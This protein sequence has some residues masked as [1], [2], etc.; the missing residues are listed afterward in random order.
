[1]K[2]P[3]LSLAAAALLAF[4]LAL[5]FPFAAAQAPASVIAGIPTPESVLGFKPGADFHLANYT[6]AI[7]YFRKL[8]AASHRIKL[9]DVGQ[10]SRGQTLVLS[11]ISSPE[12]LANLDKYLEI[13]RRLTLASGLS[14]AQ[15]HALAGQGKVVVHIDGG[16]HSTEVAGGQSMIALAYNLCAAQND[17]EINAILNNVIFVLWPTLNPD[18][19]QEVVAWYRRNVGT[20]FEV[21]PIPFLFQ[22]YVG[23]DNNRDGYMNNM[24]ESQAIT[25]QELKWNPEIWYT[26]HQTAPFPARIFIPPFVDPISP[27][28]NPILMRWLNQIGIA[29]GAYLD[30]HNMPGAIHRV[31]FDNWYPGYQDFT[32]IFR[33]SIAFFTETA[34]YGYATPHFYTLRDFPPAYRNLQP[35][36]F[37]NSPWRGGWWRLGDAVHYMV[38]AS[39]SVLDTAA[40]YHAQL[41][42]NK[43]QA[44]RD[45]IE[46]Y[47]K[48]PPYAYVIPAGQPRLAEAARLARVFAV[49]GV[50]VDQA[51]QPFLANHRSY[52]AGS[53][54]ILMDQPFAQLVRELI[55][56]QAYPERTANG[57]PIRPYDVA[58]WTLPEQMNVEVDAVRSPVTAAQRAGLQPLAS[59]TTP[60]GK[61]SGSGGV[62]LLPPDTNQHFYAMNLALDQ[63][64][65]VSIVTDPGPGVPAG[66][67]AISNLSR[68]QMQTIL[69][70]AATSAR[71]VA[72]APA[73]AAD[74]VHKPR[75]G[76]YRPWQASIDMGWTR[77]ILQNYDF[78]PLL[79]RNGDIQAS[80]LN[81]RLDVI[82]LAD[83]YPG[84]ILNGFGPGTM[85][86][87]YVG[88]IGKTGVDAL[89]TFVQNGGTLIC[90]NQASAFAIQQ[91]GLPVTNVLS[92]VSSSKFYSSGSL[93]WTHVE[94]PELAGTW[95]MPPAQ[96]V[97]FDNS[98]AFATGEG[99]RGHILAV[100]P[101]REDPLASGFLQGPEFLEG[102]AAEVE[103][104]YGKGRIYLFGFKPNWRAQAHGAYPLIFNAI[105]DSPASSHPTE[106][107]FAPTP[108]AIPPKEPGPGAL[109]PLTAR[110]GGRF[111]GGR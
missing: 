76:L 70:S 85:P 35:Q 38:G 80:D 57:S 3:K 4:G 75:V 110:R 64:A 61:I 69:N 72:S 12:N 67:A 103:A 100:Y 92:G 111:G 105:Y 44:G 17:P 16:M 86:G 21:S 15:A 45:T 60:P 95:G 11:V 46:Q 99:F 106:F 84:G 73:G 68:A 26:Q 97:M 82:I 23:H 102:K 34:L 19:Q 20:S 104:A 51:S 10:S 27:N 87:Q 18:G 36:I 63:G 40:K 43:Y 71:A 93:L 94:Q 101:N 8:A 39:M 22:K 55:E 42:Y 83:Q 81:A 28:I 109:K 2:L 108:R 62:F 24:V 53:W 91:F 50:A 89:R 1:M 98:L 56:P 58:G 107:G 33:N 41:L 96:A 79:L 47:S 30:E 7:G 88:G 90:F 25:K 5:P 65:K 49:N 54:V 59:I 77:W 14:D 74:I 6:D 13:N 48:N 66:T 78:P 32:G 9:F 52:P 31:G 29:M 37:Y